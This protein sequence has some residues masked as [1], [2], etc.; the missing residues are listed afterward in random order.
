M[1]LRRSISFGRLVLTLMLIMQ[2]IEGLM[3]IVMSVPIY[4]LLLTFPETTG[5]L[6]ERERHIAM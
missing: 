1:G 3:A 4:F 6:N 2:I 5:A